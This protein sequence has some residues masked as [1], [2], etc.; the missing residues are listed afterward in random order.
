[1]LAVE[2]YVRSN[3]AETDEIIKELASVQNCTPEDLVQNHL[4]T[5]NLF[6][7]N[8]LT[9]QRSHSLTNLIMS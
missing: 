2:N 1:M 5:T 6:S 8:Q 7:A 4:I 9:N 3:L